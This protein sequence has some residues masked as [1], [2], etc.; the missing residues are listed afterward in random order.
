MWA[1]TGLLSC[2]RVVGRMLGSSKLEV[3]GNAFEQL[4]GRREIALATGDPGSEPTGG[5]TPTIPVAVV[6]L[7]VAV[8]VLV[9]G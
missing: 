9:G 2:R 8:A 3:A 5:W 1:V 6:Y 7:A 4:V